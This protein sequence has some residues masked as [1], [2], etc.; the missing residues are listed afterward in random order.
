MDGM[1][2]APMQAMPRKSAVGGFPD[3]FKIKI[4]EYILIHY[5]NDPCKFEKGLNEIEDMR[6]QFKGLVC[7]ME[8][9]LLMK[10]YYSQM[11]L[12]K[13]RFPMEK[14]EEL[15]IPFTWTDIPE[16]S[17]S[18]TTVEDIN[19]ELVSVLYNIAAIHS[20]LASNESR[21]D[22][23]SIKNAFMN[24]QYAAGAVR[25]IRE[26]YN[27]L[28]LGVLD[29]SP[30]YMSWCCLLFLAQAQE[31]V[32]DKA[33]KEKRKN[34]VI[35]QLAASLVNMYNDCSAQLFGPDLQDLLS[36]SIL[37][38]SS[39]Y[40]SFKSGL[41]SSLK[42]Y[43]MA[44]QCQAENKPGHAVKYIEL[45]KK[46][47]DGAVKLV[48][49]DKKELLK[50]VGLYV[51][52]IITETETKLRKE[53]DIVYNARIV[54]IDELPSLEGKSMA[55]AIKFDPND[56]SVSGD[57]IF[58]ELLPTEVIK[59]ISL[60]EEEKRKFKDDILKKVNKA[61]E[62]LESFLIELHLDSLNLDRDVNEFDLPEEL[63]SCCAEFLS[64]PDIFS[65]FLSKLDEVIEMSKETDSIITT[66]IE[67]MNF[68][69]GKRV[70][71]E[72]LIKRMRQN[73]GDINERHEQAK[74]VNENLRQT[75]GD[76]STNIKI[77]GLP[78]SEIRE[79]LG[80]ELN[81]ES[82]I[83]SKTDEGQKLT[84]VLDKVDEMRKQRYK[85]INGLLEDIEN[86]Q[87][88]KQLMADK[89]DDHN[90]V[91]K[92]MLEKH[93]KTIRLIEL[94][95][96]AQEP[97]LS[98]LTD[99][100]ADFAS[101]RK[102]IHTCNYSRLKKAAELVAS[103]ESVNQG[104]KGVENGIVFYKDVLKLLNPISKTINSWKIK[105]EDEIKK[106]EK[107]K[108]MMEEKLK[109][110]KIAEETADF[111]SLFTGKTLSSEIGSG[112]N[113]E[114]QVSLD[115][116]EKNKK[117]DMMAFYRE[118]MNK[119]NSRRNITNHTIPNDD[120]INMSQSSQNIYS[121][122]MKNYNTNQMSYTPQP[123]VNAGGMY[124]I[125]SHQQQMNYQ[126]QNNGQYMPQN[127]AQN[128]PQFVLPQPVQQPYIS[129]DTNVGQYCNVPH[130]SP[131]VTPR[132]T[133]SPTI[134][135]LAPNHIS[136][137]S[138]TTIT[139]QPIQPMVQQSSAS[140]PTQMHV[141]NMI[142][143]NPSL[144]QQYISSQ[145]DPSI[146]SQ[147]SPS[148]TNLSYTVNQ[149]PSIH[150]PDLYYN[151]NQGFHPQNAMSYQ[152]P[153]TMVPQINK[154]T[155]NKLLENN[156]QP[157]Q[158]YQIDNK[159][160]SGNNG[161]QNF[162]NQF[163]NMPAQNHHHHHQQQQ[164]QQ[165]EEYISPFRQNIPQLPPRMSTMSNGTYKPKNMKFLKQEEAIKIDQ[166]LFSK[167]GFSVEQLMELAG[168]AC[169]QAIAT[170]YKDS[171][172]KDK[173]KEILII[174]G[175]GNNGGDGF[176]CARHL[177]LFGYSP[178]IYYPKPSKNKLME[179]LVKQSIHFNINFD[180]N[181]ND[182]SKFSLIVDAIF[183]FS[184]KPPLRQP[185]EDILK[186]LS[187]TETPIAS[188]D[189]PSGWDVEN[190]PLKDSCPVI[191]PNLLISLTA[192]KLCSKYFNGNAHYLGGR[193][194]PDS[195]LSQ[196]EL[197]L[198]KYE[199]IQG[200]IKL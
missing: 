149:T 110:K 152:V 179:N 158:Q 67:T 39:K 186:A 31:C 146:L 5:Q 33:I 105:F 129:L 151:V 123:M 102:K 122:P 47:I 70:V 65:M 163:Y 185:F 9:I 176:V 51:H 118:K 32:L 53:N 82:F 169:A 112:T 76:H 126:S 52:K 7:D 189:I 95:I 192:P 127:T 100:N 155:N 183:G 157:S 200:I 41:Y 145:P 130:H 193:F 49:K 75:I 104:L 166:E 168:L 93:D 16:D 34:I 71:D 171:I 198:P 161:I 44:L 191:K 60:F 84:S 73:I 62:E 11:V 97:I 124:D 113:Y 21:N 197:N 116:N 143:Q 184:F 181:I 180:E 58:E 99:A 8:Q 20:S 83:P 25:M 128:N 91:C 136:A 3:A 28:P 156:F 154:I 43:Y 165:P 61:D 46:D 106:E 42:H 131:S 153:T 2:R 137:M 66:A 79:K 109:E 159:I 80:E 26:E 1:P 27:V 6:K 90:T 35:A 188:I 132:M 120:G 94:N 121:V 142:P 29:F 12:M 196:Y 13:S 87:I 174:C 15:A 111:M 194:I 135:T 56:R 167:Y 74:K 63:L 45:S 160:P 18:G 150:K 14:G 140:I 4:K 144:S 23:D 40:L 38:E 108:I 17:M 177:K 78:V 36:S 107:R 72:D 50:N 162:H 138:H 195:L 172:L 115:N 101:L 37:E 117:V 57:D 119:R 114:T 59:G 55:D 173:N 69:S 24:F 199:G 103:F 85:L 178:R 96:N 147:S 134:T 133:P 64:K 10:R 148:I 68:V 30:S 88:Y 190:G 125:R 139:Q 164:Q 141:K 19:Y 187:L 182:L 22:S 81:I 48:T 175:P 77:L 86:N 170:E 54:N 92:K 89:Y 98:A